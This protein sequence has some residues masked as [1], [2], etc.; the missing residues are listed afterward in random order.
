MTQAW[1]DAGNHKVNLKDIDQIEFLYNFFL[2]KGDNVR[3]NY[4]STILFVSYRGKVRAEAVGFP[5][6]TK[7]LF[8]KGNHSGATKRLHLSIFQTIPSKNGARF[9]NNMWKCQCLKTRHMY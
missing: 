9:A 3:L 8:K 7:E 1:L 5:K 2:S 4:Y 6:Q